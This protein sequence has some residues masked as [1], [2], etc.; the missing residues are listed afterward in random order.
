M[1]VSVKSDAVLVYLAIITIN[2]RQM[3]LAMTTNRPRLNTKVMLI[4]SLLNMLNFSA[5][6]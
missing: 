3:Q 4:L 2:S 5:K 6:A 1:M